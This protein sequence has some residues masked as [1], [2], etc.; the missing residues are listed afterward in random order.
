MSFPFLQQFMT[1]G[2]KATLIECVHGLPADA[3]LVGSIARDVT[4]TR[5][6]VWTYEPLI[7][8]LFESE[9]WV[10]DPV[11]RHVELPSGEY[12]EVLMPEF[13]TLRDRDAITIDL[14]D[15][16]SIRI[17]GVREDASVS[18]SEDC[19]VWPTVTRHK[20]PLDRLP[21]EVEEFT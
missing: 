19:T 9:Q 16:G 7:G 17:V 18:K 2:H 14:K 13:K 1:E 5:N 8:L 6:G 12:V 11:G 10:D 20:Y 15:S 3:K 21:L 4:S